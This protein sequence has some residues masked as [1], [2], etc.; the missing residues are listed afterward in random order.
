[1]ARALEAG[2]EDEL[3]AVEAKSERFRA[4]LAGP[5]RHRMEAACDLYVA[6]FLMPKTEGPMRTVGGGGTFVPTSRDLWDE[7]TGAR[8]PNLIEEHAVAAA[9]I[10]RA[11]HWPL[12]FPQVFFPGN[13]RQPG[14]DLALGNPPWE[15]SEL[16]EE[17]YFSAKAPAIAKLK[18]K[19][20]KDAIAALSTTDPHLWATYQSDKRALDATNEF[21]RSSGRE[22]VAEDS[23][24]GR[25]I[26]ACRSQ[27]T[28]KCRR[29]CLEQPSLFQQKASALDDEALDLG[30][31][32]K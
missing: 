10:P 8:P 5:D 16:D 27:R 3:A 11:F 19:A 1:M 24:S 17:E 7:L 22:V 2:P 32:G 31:R 4:L 23:L 20:R 25:H 30:R 18:G 13:G 28:H 21:Y 29:I 6:A 15:V 12:E 14:F 26:A 9:K